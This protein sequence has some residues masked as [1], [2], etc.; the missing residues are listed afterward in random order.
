MVGT[1]IWDMSVSAPVRSYL[2]RHRSALPTVA[3]FCTCGGLGSERVFRQMTEECG[4]EPVAKMVLTEREVARPAVPIA[5]AR[6]TVQLR[7]VL[8][9]AGAVSPRNRSMA[10]RR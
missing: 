3:F 6:F 5:I 4:R 1:P 7:A 2:R 10:A 8:A 9:H